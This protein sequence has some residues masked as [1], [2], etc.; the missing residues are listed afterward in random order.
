MVGY[1]R[2]ALR[3][4]VQFV[5]FKNRGKH[6]W[7]SVILVKLQTIVCHLTKGNNSPLICGNFHTF[8]QGNLATAQ[9][10]VSKLS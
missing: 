3:N 2:D 9:T 5:Q 10:F 8:T 1:T 6:S 7:R 4:L